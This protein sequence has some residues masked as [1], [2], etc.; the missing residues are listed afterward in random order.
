MANIALL[1]RT[2]IS[3]NEETSVREGSGFSEEGSM[4]G[5][6]NYDDFKKVKWS[7]VLTILFIATLI[8]LIL[9]IIIIKTFSIKPCH[10]YA[11]FILLLL[12]ILLIIG[13]KFI[14]NIATY[15]LVTVVITIILTIFILITYDLTQS[16]CIIT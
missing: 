1:P 10:V 4:H 13:N 15:L 9:T 8:S 6:P 16:G 11:L 2:I 3:R 7:T 14:K 12:I 5:I